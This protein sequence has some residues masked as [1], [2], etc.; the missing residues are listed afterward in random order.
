MIGAEAMFKLRIWRFPGE[1][2]KQMRANA[3]FVFE[4]ASNSIDISRN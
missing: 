1:K 2:R 4:V 3:V